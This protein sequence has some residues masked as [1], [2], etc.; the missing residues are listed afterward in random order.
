MA[1]K[2]PKH[3]L[4]GKAHWSTQP[5]DAT[6]K[7]R[8]VATSGDDG[9]LAELEIVIER[10][11]RSFVEMGKAL[12]EVKNKRLYRADYATFEDYCR[13]R[14]GF[15]RTQA[16]RLIAASY[17]SGLLPMGDK[18][19]N[20][21][22]ARAVRKIAREIGPEAAAK[23]FEQAGPNPTA[24]AI[25]QAAQPALETQTVIEGPCGHDR[26]KCLACG[27]IVER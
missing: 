27:V 21:R 15:T 3:N 6:P 9:R 8:V 5:C 12:T 13:Q 10:G 14:W 7:R 24:E 4:C 25:H 18:I 16:Y 20:E 23:A 26:S 2:A 1:V 22:Q 19:T 11:C 17:I